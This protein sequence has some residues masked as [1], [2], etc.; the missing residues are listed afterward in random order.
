MVYKTKNYHDNYEDDSVPQHQIKTPYLATLGHLILLS[1]LTISKP[2]WS[3]CHPI[4]SISHQP[5]VS[6]VFSGTENQ[7]NT[8]QVKQHCTPNLYKVKIGSG[9]ELLSSFVVSERSSGS[10]STEVVDRSQTSQ[11]KP[12]SGDN[13]SNSD[14]KANDGDP[15]LGVLR[16]RIQEK[17]PTPRKPTVY[18]QGRVSYFRSDNIFAGVDPVDDGLLRPGVTLLAVPSLGPDT[19]LITSV[20]GN[21][22]RYGDRSQLDYNQLKVKLGVRQQLLKRTYGELGWSNQQLFKQEGGDRFAHYNS[23]YLRLSRRDWLVKNLAL[24]TSYKLTLRFA[25]PDTRSK[26]SNVFR[27]SLAYYP[28][29]RFKAAL[30]YQLALSD[31]TER[32]RYDD[33]HQLIGR[34]SYKIS[35][36]SQIYLYGGQSF[37]SSSNSRINFDGTVFGTGMSFNLPLF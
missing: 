27:A 16:L 36:N 33:Y 5:A 6:L 9:G 18:L 3:G 23:L 35:S 13:S 10:S 17:P 28:Y 11:A 7:G 12:A 21:L 14:S 2:A 26:I 22:V 30:N 24:D 4:D 1:T 25:D 19:K 37:G 34:V 8:D 32:E 31:Y 29:P 15:E 20:S